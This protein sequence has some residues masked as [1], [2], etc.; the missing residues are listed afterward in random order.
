MSSLQGLCLILRIGKTK[1]VAGRASGCDPRL[2]P[3]GQWLGRTLGVPS[4]PEPPVAHW[5]AQ[6][7]SGAEL[8]RCQGGDLW[9]YSCSCVTLKHDEESLLPAHRLMAGVDLVR[10]VHGS[11]LK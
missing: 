7:T 4:C 9:P 11:M 3:C 6:E 10:E 5:E 8:L 2:W 1:T